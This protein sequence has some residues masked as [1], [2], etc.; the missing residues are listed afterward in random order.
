MFR[1][2]AFIDNL[3]PALTPATSAPNMTPLGCPYPWAALAAQWKNAMTNRTNDENLIK[4]IF[5]WFCCTDVDCCSNACSFIEAIVFV[6]HRL[7]TYSFN[8]PELITQIFI[9]IARWLCLQFALIRRNNLWHRKS[10]RNFHFLLSVIQ[11]N[12]PWICS[13]RWISFNSSIIVRFAKV[14]TFFINY[15]NMYSWLYDKP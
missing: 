12:S 8:T 14:Y 3:P 9:D 11:R 5:D 2:N 4:F 15:I 6:A 1:S 13:I 7:N 10:L